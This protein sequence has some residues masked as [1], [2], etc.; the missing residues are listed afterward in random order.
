MQE[1]AVVQDGAQWAATSEKLDRLTEKMD[2]FINMMQ[3]DMAILKTDVAGL[4]TDV[5][6]LKTDVAGLKTDVAG[7]K[8][9]V[10]GLET[11]VAGLN[12]KVFERQN[13]DLVSN[14]APVAGKAGRTCWTG[15]E[16]RSLVPSTAL[17]RGTRHFHR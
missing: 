9:D 4:K 12:V 5:T 14:K 6:G 16:I 2:A 17:R 1:P 11:N 13:D 15:T 10:A 3:K 7:L 8:T